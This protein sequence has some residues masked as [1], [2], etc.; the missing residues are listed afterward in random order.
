MQRELALSLCLA[1]TV[2]LLVIG[3]VMAWTVTQVNPAGAQ[4]F[5]E[6]FPIIPKANASE[7]DPNLRSLPTRRRPPPT[8]G[9]RGYRPN[10]RGRL[11][12]RLQDGRGPAL[13]GGQRQ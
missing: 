2:R 6:R 1:A 8:A 3:L 10:S 12:A 4:D 13:P 5:E 11:L 9:F 7:P